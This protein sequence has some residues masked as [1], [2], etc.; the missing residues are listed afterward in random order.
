M[1]VSTEQQWPVRI[2]ILFVFSECSFGGNIPL[3]RLRCGRA[4]LYKQLAEL[5]ALVTEFREDPAAGEGLKVCGSLMPLLA[6]PACTQRPAARAPGKR[7]WLVVACQ[8]TG[9]S[10]GQARLAC[11]L[12]S[13]CT[14]CRI[15]CCKL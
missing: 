1:P 13:D 9:D 10:G 14:R 11:G 8:C 4:G 5:R 2:I 3:E 12:R 7:W 6:S 15:P